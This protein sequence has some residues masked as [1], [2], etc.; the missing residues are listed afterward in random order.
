MTS[1]NLNKKHLLAA[2]L[3]G[4]S[5]AVL[6]GVAF[7]AV[8]D[9]GAPDGNGPDVVGN[10][11]ALGSVGILAT[12]HNM[13]NTGGYNHTGDIS[14]P[15]TGIGTGPQSQICVFCHTPHGGNVDAGA[16]LWNKASNSA[17]VYSTYDELLSTSFNGDDV[18]SVFLT[19]EGGG[20][21]SV[22]LACLSCHDGVQALNVVANAPNTG[23]GVGGN[24]N[25]DPT[26]FVTWDE[27][28]TIVSL[29]GTAA[30][31]EEYFDTGGGR[32]LWSSLGTD[33]R[34]DHP[35]GMEYA[36]GIDTSV[37]PAVLTDKDFVDPSVDAAGYWYVDVPDIANTNGVPAERDKGDMQLYLRGAVG[38]E[39]PYVECGSCHDPHLDNVAF[40]RVNN[41]NSNVC[42]SCHNK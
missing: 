27:L 13:S 14:L 1:V 31:G 26:G 34:N 2:V 9:P 17:T 25:F 8:I 33:L 11:L 10:G 5:V 12:A 20:A 15:S 3:A 38:S 18:G 16:P 23:I 32:N 41:D 22:S 42:L 36:G 21:P 29:R 24:G 37:S 28:D 19:P 30:E 35:I 6:S 4:A 39:K 40:L 7:A